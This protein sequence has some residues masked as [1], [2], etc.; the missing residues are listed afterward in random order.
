MSGEELWGLCVPD[1]VKLEKEVNLKAAQVLANFQVG[2]L[3]TIG[4]VMSVECCGDTYV[5]ELDLGAYEGEEGHTKLGVDFKMS[6]NGDWIGHVGANETQESIWPTVGGIFFGGLAH[7]ADR[8][9]RVAA[10][11]AAAMAAQE[12]EE[13][14]AI[15]PS[16][17]SEGSR[18]L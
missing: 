12:A 1:L 2:Q 3:H 5:I 18:S 8:Y 6:L 16:G 17:P 4:L 9:P 14:A 7:F 13:L 11:V 10:A 15:L